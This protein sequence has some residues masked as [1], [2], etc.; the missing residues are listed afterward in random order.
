MHIVIWMT[1]MESMNQSYNIINNSNCE[2]EKE[3]ENDL[4]KMV[5]KP[6][7]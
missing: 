1:L 7:E 3:Q 5:V 4:S 2:D 6:W